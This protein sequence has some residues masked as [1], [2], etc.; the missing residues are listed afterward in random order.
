MFDIPLTCATAIHQ[1]FHDHIEEIQNATLLL[2]GRPA[3]AR[4]HNVIDE[5]THSQRIS[6]RAQREIAVLHELLTL[7]NVHDHNR[8]EASYFAMLDPAAPYVAEICL[9]TDRLENAMKQAGIADT[10][11][12]IFSHAGCS[13]LD[14]F[15]GD[16]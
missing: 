8:P 3:L 16:Q 4:V 5:L 14:P 1:L 9:I 7:Q 10:S 15:R 12:D 2:G 13:D 6:R 11:S